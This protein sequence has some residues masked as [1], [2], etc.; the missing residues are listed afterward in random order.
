MVPFILFTRISFIVVN[1]KFYLLLYFA[2]FVFPFFLFF[3]RKKLQISRVWQEMKNIS[4]ISAAEEQ[5]LVYFL[6]GKV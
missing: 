6:E 2:I 4:N 3:T 5:K 1:L